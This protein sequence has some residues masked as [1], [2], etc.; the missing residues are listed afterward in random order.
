MTKPVRP[1]AEAEAEFRY[2]IRWYDSE[3]AGLGDRNPSLAYRSTWADESVVGMV[4][5]LHA[6]MASACWSVRTRAYIFID[7]SRL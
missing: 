6:S 5:H 1:T 2:Y 3:S 4:I 7:V